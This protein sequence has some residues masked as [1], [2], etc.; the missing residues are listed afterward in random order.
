[1]VQ[2]TAQ[3]YPP[4]PAPRRPTPGGGRPEAGVVRPSLGSPSGRT[5]GDGPGARPQCARDCRVQGSGALTCRRWEPWGLLS[6][7]TPLAPPAL[8]RPMGHAV[9]PGHAARAPV[10]L[11]FLG[12]DRD[13]QFTA[14]TLRASAARRTPAEDGAVA[15]DRLPDRALPD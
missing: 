3:T 11:H 9:H 6:G 10:D 2:V 12:E 8:R 1:M 14:R 4:L 15:R 5:T 7:A 13:H